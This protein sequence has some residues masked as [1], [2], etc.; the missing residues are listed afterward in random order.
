MN[1]TPYADSDGFHKKRRSGNAWAEGRVDVCVAAVELFP[2]K[3]EEKTPLFTH[4]DGA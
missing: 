1:S 2:P 4:G 3:K